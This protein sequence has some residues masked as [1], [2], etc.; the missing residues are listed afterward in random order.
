MST[1]YLIDIDG[2]VCEDIPN[3]ES[4]RFL[5]AKI[6]PGA[7]EWVNKFN[8]EGQVWFFTART[9]KH[10]KATEQWLDKQ[11]FQY[12]GV[13]YG[14]PRINANQEYHWIDNRPV[15]ATW[16]EDGLIKI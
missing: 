10:K 13:V 1:I 3:E 14:K 8:L 11:G 4:A 12:L 6:I 2:T 16:V 9:D 15:Q 5:T 7:K